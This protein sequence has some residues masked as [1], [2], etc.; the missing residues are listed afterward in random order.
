MIFLTLVSGWHSP[1]T[2]TE[3][4]RRSGDFHS[5]WALQGPARC[6]HGTVLFGSS[7]WVFKN[8]WINGFSLQCLVSLW[9]CVAINKNPAKIGSYSNKSQLP[10]QFDDE[11]VLEETPRAL[12]ST[13]WPSLL[14]IPSLICLRGSKE[15]I[16]IQGITLEAQSLRTAGCWSIFLAQKSELTMRIAWLARKDY[17]SCMFQKYWEIRS[18]PLPPS[19]STLQ[20]CQCPLLRLP[21]RIVMQPIDKE[22]SLQMADRMCDPHAFESY[23]TWDWQSG[24]N[25]WSLK[26]A[27]N[28]FNWIQIC[29]STGHFWRF[30]QCGRTV[31]LFQP[32]W[33]R[34]IGQLRVE[35]AM[36]AKAD[37]VM[38][39]KQAR[40]KRQSSWYLWWPT[41]S[42][43]MMMMVVVVAV[44]M[45]ITVNY[46]SYLQ[47]LMFVPCL[48]AFRAK[49]TRIKLCAIRRDPQCPLNIPSYWRFPA[50][51]FRLLRH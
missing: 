6:E 3:T 15:E 29:G 17:K 37:E 2:Q 14:S 35:M 45:M 36:R 47:R 38:R 51:G 25:S 27:V 41:T 40:L 10:P 19:Q 39:L 43:M 49:C 26:S 22:P 44:M 5:A 18:I 28:Q 50:L 31:A 8:W 12:D 32:L 48:F 23:E 9:V 20:S 1:M 13:T 21:T 34:T 11:S 30:F 7:S 33:P 16:E 24:G 42:W 4:P 46:S